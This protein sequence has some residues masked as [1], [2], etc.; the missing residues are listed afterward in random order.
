MVCLLDKCCVV[1]SQDHPL[2]LFHCLP[3]Q[4]IFC[5]VNPTLR[6]WAETFCIANVEAMAM[7]LPIISFGV[8]GMGEY[9]CSTRENEN[10]SIF[11]QSSFTG[12]VSRAHPE[13]LAQAVLQI[14]QQPTTFRE[15]LAKNL[16]WTV[17]KYFKLQKSMQKYEIL[18]SY[19]YQHCTHAHL[20]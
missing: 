15:Q 8:G 9:L 19:L 10:S 7:A 17:Q 2:I 3:L 5:Q 11:Q 13:D 18:Y 4:T 12:M 16:R 20:A 6:A 14:L 1:H